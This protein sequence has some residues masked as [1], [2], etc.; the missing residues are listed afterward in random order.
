MSSSVAYCLG[1]WIYLLDATDDIIDDKK[2]GNYNPLLL[3]SRDIKEVIENI[4]KPNLNVCRVE[5]QKGFELIECKDLITILENILYLG[6]E[7]KQETVLG[8]N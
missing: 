6:I 2:S 7:K 5:A 1:K 4:A 8:E 3:E